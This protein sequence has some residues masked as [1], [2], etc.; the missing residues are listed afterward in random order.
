MDIPQTTDFHCTNAIP[1]QFNQF[2]FSEGQGQMWWHSV[3]SDGPRTTKGILYHY[4]HIVKLSN[5]YTVYIYSTTSSFSA[6]NTQIQAISTAAWKNIILLLIYPNYNNWQTICCQ[7][8]VKHKTVNI[9]LIFITKLN[10]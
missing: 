3:I 2:R 7:K 4:R 1:R 10:L 6:E 8:M 9:P 5:Y